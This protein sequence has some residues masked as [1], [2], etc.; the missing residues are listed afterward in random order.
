MNRNAFYANECREAVAEYRAQAVKHRSRS[1]LRRCYLEL[2][3][4]NRRQARE[5]ASL[6]A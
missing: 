6:A 4:K 1:S 2:A 3:W 5:Y